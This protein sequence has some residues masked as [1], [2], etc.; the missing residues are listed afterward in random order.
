MLLAH[1]S[2]HCESISIVYGTM[3]FHLKRF[4]IYL[5][6]ALLLGLAC[7]CQSA[8]KKKKKQLAT[9][10]LYVET[11]LHGMQHTQVA[12]IFR[13]SPV[14][15]TVEQTPFLTEGSVA[16]A[17]VINTVG[18]FAMSIQF[19]NEGKLLLEQYTS[20]NNGRK[21]AVLCQF[22][23]DLAHHRWLAAP[24]ISKRISNG[25][26]VFTPD[27]SREEAEEIVLGLNNVS[28]TLRG[29]WMHDQ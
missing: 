8:E 23:K 17:K 4:N 15:V 27:A 10:H 26:F 3:M 14:D 7:G 21:I 13:D 22:G 6:V 18:G 1:I 9:L 12:S 5:I 19:N 28:K 16:E 25:L 20:A 2:L 29:N 24:V 11:S